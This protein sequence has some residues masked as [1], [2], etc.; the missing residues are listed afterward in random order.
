MTLLDIVKNQREKANPFESFE[1]KQEDGSFIVQ[2]GDYWAGD[3]KVKYLRK[4]C[5]DQEC[6]DNG[7]V[8]TLLVRISADV[9]ARFKGAY[10]EL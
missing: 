10:G 1:L 4:H 6:F 9:W 2:V 7:V 5:L 8:A 3:A